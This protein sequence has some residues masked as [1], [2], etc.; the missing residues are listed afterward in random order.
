MSSV[1]AVRGLGWGGGAISNSEWKGPKLR[2]VLLYAGISEENIDKTI[3]H[4]QFEALDRD[5]EKFY[6]A[7]VPA[8]YIMKPDSEAI[9]ALEMNGVPL[10]PDHGYPLRVVVPGIVGARNVKWVCKIIASK[11][12]SQSHWQQKD[13]KGFGCYIDWDNLDYNKAPAIQELPVQSAIT[14]PKAGAAVTPDEEGNVHI[15]GYAWSGGGRGIIRVDVSRDNGK[16]W[17][18]ATL[19]PNGQPKHKSWAWTQWQHTFKLTPPTTTLSP[20]V[21]DGNSTSAPTTTS[22]STRKSIPDELE[23]VVKAVDSSYNVQPEEWNP[24]WN[25]RGVLSTAWHR[26][27]VKVNKEE[28]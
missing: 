3:Q 12:E 28:L 21:G 22:Q 27:K 24:I 11:D 25:V 17:E 9:L 16:T 14:N 19:T 20:S 1:K 26:V 18:E 6:G 7:S 8:H 10:P 5:F 2:D 15:R 23:L 4:I 13:Y